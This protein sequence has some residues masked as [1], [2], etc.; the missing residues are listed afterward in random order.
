MIRLTKWVLAAPLLIALFVPKAHAQVINAT[1]CSSSAVQAALNSVAADGTTVLIPA[2]SCTWATQV[3]YTA[4]HAMVL[5]GQTT[6]TGTPATV[7]T[8]STVI[9]DGM[10]T[11]N[12]VLFLKTTAGKTFRMTGITFQNT[13]IQEFNGAIQI[14]G[15]W[16]ASLSPNIRLDHINLSGL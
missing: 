3:S 10:T 7:C 11:D 15:N 12:P 16:P 9:N 2:G 5:A 8:D 6:C 4:T 14:N 13:A 1:S